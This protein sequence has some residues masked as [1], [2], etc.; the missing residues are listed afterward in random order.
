MVRDCSLTNMLTDLSSVWNVVIT[1][2]HFDCSL[3]VAVSEEAKKGLLYALNFH[4]V[5]MPLCRGRSKIRV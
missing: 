1:K 3:L 2:N 5:S 4:Y